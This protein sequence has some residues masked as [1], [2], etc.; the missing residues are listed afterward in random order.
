MIWSSASR[1]PLSAAAAEAAAE[2]ASLGDFEPHFCFN[3]ISEQSPPPAGQEGSHQTV[4][5]VA[6][7]MRQHEGKVKVSL[8]NTW[9]CPLS[10]GVSDSEVEV[11][12]V[13][14]N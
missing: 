13:F 11:E 10:H 3:C 5:L 8:G 6:N 14:F 12:S 9:K 7:T 4:F 2:V 1:R